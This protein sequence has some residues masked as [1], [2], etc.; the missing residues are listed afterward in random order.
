CPAYGCAGAFP[1]PDRLPLNANDKVDGQALP[2]PVPGREAPGRDF[3]APRD[4]LELRLASIWEE[5][6]GSRPIGVRDDFFELGGHSLLAVQLMARL[7]AAFGRSLPTAAV[8]R[9]PTVEGLAALLREGAAPARRGALVE[10]TPG[11]ARALFCVHPIGGD[12]LCYAHLPRPLGG[13]MAV[14][15]LQVPDRDGEAPWTTLEEM[16]RHYVGCVRET[17]PAGPYALAGWSMGGVVAFEMAR[18]LESAGEQVALLALMDAG[19]DDFGGGARVARFAGDLA[20]LLGLDLAAVS[21]D[22][23]RLTAPEPLAA[24]PAA[25]EKLG[26]TLG[27]DAA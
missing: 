16:A 1:P 25:A 6:L 8:L 15:A 26:V 20:R 5:L 17:Q 19:R 9:H 21:I 27:P 12:V 4:P 13:E 11:G 22:L 10:M 3:V 7:Q 24:L 14:H 18:Q 23:A 2:A